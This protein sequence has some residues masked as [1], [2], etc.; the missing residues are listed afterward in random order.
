MSIEEE[1]FKKSKPN[2]KKLIAYGFVE[3]KGI[4]TYSTLMSYPTFKVVINVINE[5]VKGKI[6]DLDTKEEYTQFRIQKQVGE[7]AGKI[8]KEY[9]NILDKIK[10]PALILIILFVNNPIVLLRLYTKLME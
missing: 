8:K 4:Y 7:F 6:I 1:L 5:K 3:E 2:K 10:N 9:I